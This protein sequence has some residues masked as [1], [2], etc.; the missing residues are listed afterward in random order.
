M[1]NK[2]SKFFTVLVAVVATMLLLAAS[3]YAKSK[4][5]YV[6]V[7]N[8][9]GFHLVPAHSVHNGQE[10]VDM[11]NCVDEPESTEEPIVDPIDPPV[12]ETEEPKTKVIPVEETPEPISG[13]IVTL[14]P[15]PVLQEQT[16]AVNKPILAQPCDWCSIALEALKQLTRIADSLESGTVITTGQ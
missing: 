14:E 10:E 16:I 2:Q 13:S 8:P 6:C 3:A 9:S 5:G 12:D 1:T 7:E 11:S 4:S 15:D